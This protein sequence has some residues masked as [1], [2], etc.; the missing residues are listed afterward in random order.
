MESKSNNMLSVKYNIY[1]FIV[2]SIL[3]VICLCSAN[4]LNAQENIK[5]NHEIHSLFHVNGFANEMQ[6]EPVS[7]FCS[8]GEKSCGIRIDENMGRAFA[9]TGNSLTFATDVCNKSLHYDPANISFV[10][11]C[12]GYSDGGC[13]YCTVDH[14]HG[15]PSCPN[16]FPSPAAY[17]TAMGCIPP[18]YVVRP[19]FIY[20]QLDQAGTVVF[21]FIY[22]GGSGTH[23]LDADF[24]IWGPF[25]SKYEA[26]TTVSTNPSWLSGPI[27]CSYATATV[28]TE[29][30]TVNFASE[31][32]NKYFVMLVVPH[33]CANRSFDVNVTRN[34]FSTGTFKT[35]VCNINNVTVNSQSCVL[36]KHAVTG[37]V[38]YTNPP[39]GGRLCITSS[40]VSD[41]AY[42]ATYGATSTNYVLNNVECTGETNDI[43]AW[44][45]Y[46][47]GTNTG[48][49]FTVCY[50]SPIGLCPVMEVKRHNSGS[51]VC[52]SFGDTI[53]FTF[54]NAANNSLI[55]LSTNP[56]TFSYTVNGLLQTITDYS[57]T[58]PYKITA[59]EPA[60]YTGIS[61]QTASC[62]GTISSTAYSDTTVSIIT[63]PIITGVN[64]FAACIPNVTNS[65][66]YVI[67]NDM[68]STYTVFYRKPDMTTGYINGVPP[69]PNAHHF[70]A[71]I[72]DWG[73]EG[74][75]KFAATHDLLG[76]SSDTFSVRRVLNSMRPDI[77]ASDTSLCNSVTLSIQAPFRITTGFNLILYKLGISS[78]INTFFSSSITSPYTEGSP[79]PFLY[80]VDSPGQYY[81][82]IEFLL[83]PEGNTGCY[84]ASMQYSDTIE[85]TSCQLTNPIVLP[86]DSTI[87]SGSS[88]TLT[89]SGIS[90]ATFKWYDS[91]TNGTLLHVGNNYDVSPALTIHYYVS[92]T[93][94]GTEST[95]TDV[96][97]T[98]VPLPDAP[99]PNNVTVCYDGNYHT[100]SATA[101]ISE[102]IVWYTAV[103]GGTITTAP[104]INTAGTSI[105]FAAAKNNTTHCES[106][107]R[108]EV[109][110]TINALP[111]PQITDNSPVCATHTNQLTG[112]PAGGTW[113]SLNTSVA[114]MN[115]TGLVS[116]LSAGTAA[117][118]YIYTDSNGCT[119][120]AEVNVTVSAL[121][122]VT[123]SGNSP[124]CAMHTNQ[125][126]GTPASGTWKSLNTSVAT[127]NGTGLVSGLSA[128]TATI[129]YIYTDG[130]SCTDSAEVNVTVHALPVVAISGNSPICAMHTNQLTGTPAGGTWKSLNTSIATIDDT[131]LVYGVTSGM[132]TIRYIVGNGNCSDS[133][134]VNITVNALPNAPIANNINTC[135]DGNYHTAGATASAGESIIWYTAATGGTVTTAPSINTAGTSTAFA[136]AKNDTTNCESAT[137]TEVSVTITSAPT[138]PSL[139]ISDTTICTG[140]SVTLQ[141]NGES[142]AIFKWYLSP[143]GGVSVYTGATYSVSPLSLTIYYVSQTI[144]SCESTNRASV[145][146]DVNNHYYIPKQ[147][148]GSYCDDDAGYNYLGNIYIAGTYINIIVP[149]ETACDTSVTL[150]VTKNST[151]NINIYDTICTGGSYLFNGTLYTTTGSYTANLS[152]SLGCDS[153]V[154][155]NLAVLKSC[156]PQIINIDNTYYELTYGANQ[157]NITG[158]S[159]SEL[160]VLF[161]ISG[162]SVDVNTISTGIY[163]VSI[164]EV[165]TTIVTFKQDGNDYYASTEKTVTILVK[166]ATLTITVNNDT[167]KIGDDYPSFKCTYSGFVYGEDSTVL[168]KFPVILCSAINTKTMG[169]YP[170]V[171]N[172]AKADNYIIEYINGALVIKGSTGKL[173]NAFTPY[174]QDRLNDIFGEGY[175]LYIFNRWGSCLY[176]GYSGWDGTYKG[177]MVSPGV[178]YYYAKDANGDEYRG[179]VM[180]VKSH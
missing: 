15:D 106:A 175:E 109:S 87:C 178:Y 130:N 88:V 138:A 158:T 59:F 128:G 22:S 145:Q 143:S 97:V 24:A 169:E 34:A 110:V 98:V 150:I 27:A 21:D 9:F 93:I 10:P 50:Q 103:T 177:K 111:T 25:D 108:T 154:T 26:F 56:V 157:F 70:F 54:K 114:I 144:N 47:N 105:A 123:I 86:S 3:I 79:C 6:S 81:V 17:Q 95:R 46:P 53:H 69:S 91:L 134:T 100:A 149:S 133:T 99:I 113:K 32:V 20:M 179:S 129:R 101:G 42:Y 148:T 28:P 85:I 166:P 44:F 139:N 153:I 163:S 14:T 74:I 168:K 94:L 83:P 33:Y 8:Y 37:I 76:C 135:Y 132:A 43:I 156:N 71:N 167:V 7:G 73:Q 160:P 117:I 64:Y 161:D 141:A 171:A 57:G 90:G 152:S 63:P 60:Q 41:T 170:I 174:T 115:G 65:P 45:E 77:S 19:R 112:T 159:S 147:V 66:L 18:A 92:Q 67:Q 162:T 124:I 62:I 58:N 49:S 11:G 31:H 89:A 151:Y 55:D 84:D 136:A 61:I 173:P 102:S 165:G 96:T 35:D 68:A 39:P 29:S 125:L 1:R 82:E 38:S 137:R 23:V 126:T 119:D 12:D 13:P 176:K 36:S 131:G 40:N 30:L 72:A 155:L 52:S 142:G 107:T 120:S 80:N 127:V 140:A 75:Y 5:H 180:L 122:V 4:F 146:I 172:G 104:S 164:R 51:A 78:P 121:P 48:C 16:E 116:G 118:R 2:L